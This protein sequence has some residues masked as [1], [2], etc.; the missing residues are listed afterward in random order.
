MN[1]VKEKRMQKVFNRKPKGYPII[2][3]RRNPYIKA[4]AISKKK[5]TPNPHVD[6]NPRTVRKTPKNPGSK[7][8]GRGGRPGGKKGN[9]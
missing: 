5:P 6:K 8:T 3:K 1:K 7:S 4:E 9:R 2:K